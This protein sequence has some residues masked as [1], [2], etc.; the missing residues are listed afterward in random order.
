LGGVFSGQ[1]LTLIIPW[2]N[3]YVI[4][5][6]LIEGCARVEVFPPGHMYDSK[7]GMLPHPYHHSNWKAGDPFLLTFHDISGGFVSWYCPI[8]YNPDYLPEVPADLKKIREGFEKA[9]VR[10]MM[11]DVPWG[12]LLSG[13]LDSSLVA[14][15][16]SR[17][18]KNQPDNPFPRLHS[19]SIGIEGSPDLKAAKEV[20]R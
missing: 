17:Y 10:R 20:R 7:Q 11:S 5:K 4:P 16:A 3:A 9:V 15:V 14:S 6:A 19:F 18:S 1:L 13:G 2:L 12:V 8:W